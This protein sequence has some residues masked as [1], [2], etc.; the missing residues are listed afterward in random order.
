MSLGVRRG[1]ALVGPEGV[2]GQEGGGGERRMLGKKR[3]RTSV[4]R[5]LGVVGGEEGGSGQVFDER[6]RGWS[7]FLF[8]GRRCRK[9]IPMLPWQQAWEHGSQVETAT[10][11]VLPCTECTSSPSREQGSSRRP[12]GIS[13]RL[14]RSGPLA[15]NPLTPLAFD[16]P[17]GLIPKDQV[18]QG[19]LVWSLASS[20]PKLCSKQ[21]NFAL[22]TTV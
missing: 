19:E 15:G 20:R 5:G 8:K 2:R 13:V 21:S 4:V 18:P 14:N 1:A 6:S 3:A 22:L 10:P 12:N 16:W 11:P 9:V 7:C 17:R